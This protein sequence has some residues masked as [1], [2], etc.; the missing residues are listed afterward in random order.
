MERSALKNTRG[1]RYGTAVSLLQIGPKSILYDNLHVSTLV[2]V[3]VES[4]DKKIY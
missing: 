4:V 2:K 3:S 1:W